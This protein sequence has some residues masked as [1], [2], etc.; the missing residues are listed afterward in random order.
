[1]NNTQAVEQVKKNGKRKLIP[2]II[3][4]AIGAIIFIYWLSN[5]GWISTDDAQIQGNL[6]PIG[7][8]VSGYVDKI[9]VKENQPVAIGDLLVQLDSRDLETKLKNA[10]A[11]Q[12]RL[13]EH[14]SPYD[15]QYVE[16]ARLGISKLVAAGQPHL[17]A[18]R[19]VLG[20]AYGQVIRQATAMAFID[21]FWLLGVAMMVVIPL[22]FIM[23]RQA[24]QTGQR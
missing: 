2:I 9:A 14:V 16:M 15:P 21:C 5:R 6:V 10:E 1:L 24:R 7:S 8:R 12:A 23:R 18:Q 3:V 13:V 11:N 20:L 17:A 4:L 22:V 19:E